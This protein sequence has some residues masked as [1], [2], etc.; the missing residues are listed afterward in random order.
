MEAKGF[1]ELEE[2]IDVIIIP[3]KGGGSGEAD[4]HELGKQS[5]YIPWQTLDFA[6]LTSKLPDMHK[7]ASKWI[8]VFEEETT[9]RTLSIG[10]IKAVWA[11]TIG[12]P[13]MENILR[14]NGNAWMIDPNADGTEFNLS[15]TALWASLRKEYP[16]QVDLKA[17]K[18]EPL[19]DT[20]NP[21]AYI[22]RQSKRWKQ[23]T[24]EDPENSLRL[25]KIFR[26]SI[27]EAMP[28]P[29][30][31]RLEDVVGLAS[32]T[33]RKFCDHVIH[34]IDRHRKEEQ[35]LREQERA[36]QRKVSQLQLTELTN[37]SK[38]KVQAPV[39]NDDEEAQ[40]GAI[41]APAVA[42]PSDPPI[43]HQSPAPPPQAPPVVYV[44]IQQP[45][46][47]GKKATAQKGNRVG[48]HKRC[49]GCNQPGHNRRDCPENPWPAQQEK[50]RG[51]EGQPTQ[52]GN[53]SPANPGG[54]PKHGY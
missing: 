23:E 30:K 25:T 26:N 31:S 34:A 7:G 33:H 53:A 48:Q 12:I 49:W 19:T 11:R 35:K 3:Y 32:K 50:G 37:K 17:L 6:G 5:R 52:S 46:G 1:Q 28:G 13:A 42:V 29:V 40:S 24:E 36:V 14:S 2:E 39:L 20:E 44:Y 10:D 15:R 9:G 8:K 21:A 4:V 45:R 22:S 54:G 41:V 51:S 18:S 16:I 38:K 43:H 47:R 27:I